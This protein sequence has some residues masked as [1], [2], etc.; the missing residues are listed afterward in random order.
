MFLSISG[1]EGNWDKVETKYSL[2]D[3]R[4]LNNMF[5]KYGKY[6]LEY[7]MKTVYKMNLNKLLPHILP[8][9]SSVIESVVKESSCEKACLNKVYFIINQLI[10]ISF[11]NFSDEIKQDSE[12]TEAFENILQILIS[13][14]IPDAAVILDEFRIH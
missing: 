4:F 1:Y 2:P 9:V 7:F 13:L 14:S 8:S 10:T 11:L 5:R 3:T 12:L 6:D